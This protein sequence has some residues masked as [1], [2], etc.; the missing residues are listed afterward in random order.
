MKISK[1]A[2]KEYARCNRIY[3]LE[4][5]YLKKLDNDLSYFDEEK[6]LDILKEMFDEV[7]GEELIE[8]KEQIEEMQQIYKDV[9]RYALE[10]ASNT[11]GGTFIYY[12]DT[13]K[14]KCFSF[15]D[16]SHEFYCYLDGYL[17]K[18]NEVIVIEVKATTSKKYKELGAKNKPLFI[19]KGNIL[20]LNQINEDDSLVY[21]HYQRL[22][23]PFSSVGQYVFD[24][25]IE[26][27]IIENAIYHN[28]PNLLNKNFKYYLA[29]LN[30]DYIFDGKYENDQPIYTD[31]LINFVDLTDITR[32]YLPEIQKIQDDIVN[33]IDRKELKEAIFGKKCCINKV[34]EC[35]FLK[36]CFPFLK[37]KGSILEYMNTKKF[38]PMRLTKESLIN[39]GKYKLTDIE[40]SWLTDKN[41]LIQRECFENNTTY[42]NKEKIQKAISML[43]YPIYHLDFESF[44]CP[45][46]RF[47]FEKPYS[48]SL[49]QFS[50]H[51]E[52]S[53]GECNII[54]D[55]YSFLVK[56]FNDNRKELVEK[57]ID[58]I[59]LE[60]GGTV[61][62]YNKN[63]EK[64]RLQELIS[65]F[66][67]YT[68]K[69]RKI[70]D[71]LFDLM[72]IVKTNKELYLRLGF[73]EEESKEVNYYH[74]DLM[75]KY[76]IKKVLPLFSNLSYK[77]LD[78]QNGTEAIYTY[79]KFK[80]ASTDE[81]EMLRKNL[82]EYCRLDTW[83]MVVILN[84]LRKL[85]Q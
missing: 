51:I 34:N 53:P 69:L 85:V 12:A 62:V 2:F 57:L 55:N 58:I 81:I 49:F 82:L 3:P 38:G 63:F 23:D 4:N 67:E 40:K 13:K 43:K 71:A 37:E 39:Q 72:D 80:D 77:E 20:I 36:I 33:E 73:S 78:V 15:K 35:M 5:I 52:K 24:L 19:E 74:S 1:T 65:I 48:Q 83:A 61:L 32:L 47:R 84:N 25:A 16:K 54:K 22:F 9:E 7:T 68:S 14:Q 17:E 75:G 60:N 8:Y 70:V 42:I 44:P 18:D 29:I 46:P 10:I 59:D 31:E 26:R 30:S 28:E 66:P 56:D 45:L 64:N 41:N 27:Y 79:L 50:I 76:S 6:V 21:R 11:F